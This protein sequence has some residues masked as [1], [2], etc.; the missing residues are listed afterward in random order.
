[1]KS[2]NSIL[3]NLFLFIGLCWF[4]SFSLATTDAEREQLVRLSNEVERL[5]RIISLAK[6]QAGD[7]DRIQFDYERLESDLRLVKQGIVEHL[8]Q[9]FRDP[10]FQGQLRGGAY[11]HVD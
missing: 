8:T 9:E 3:T 10:D 5:H 2:I 6:Q 11:N 1:M 7:H 4:S